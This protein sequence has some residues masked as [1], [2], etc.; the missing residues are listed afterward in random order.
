MQET[1]LTQEGYQKLVEELEY[2]KTTGRDETAE[3]I[4]VARSFGDLSEN[5]EYNEAMNEQ[6]KMEARIAQIEN[7]LQNA[8]IIDETDID[9]VTVRAG[10]K[11][12][13]K[14]LE[15][16]ETVEYHIL[17]KTEADPEKGIIS[18]QSPIGKSLLGHKAGETI[19]VEVPSG[20]IL[21]FKIMK[22]LKSN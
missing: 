16:G 13:L 8:R 15:L 11:V 4:S 18:D 10:S 14:D 3:R 12:K 17:G 9:T 1:F 21:K 7:D 20:K 6:A 22:I 19:S 2:L 5:A